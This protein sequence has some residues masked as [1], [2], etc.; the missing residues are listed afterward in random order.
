MPMRKGIVFS[1]DA[2]FALIILSTLLV[3]FFV[4]SE[5]PVLDQKIS[6]LATLGRDYLT[7]KY[8]QGIA[9]DEAGFAQKT[10]L[11]ISEARA[12]DFLERQFV[13]RVT[14]L[15]YP[16]A[17]GCTSFPCILDS[18]SVCLLAQEDLSDALHVAWVATQR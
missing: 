10:G 2:L 1:I 15:Q 8:R 7:L 14:L 17:C 11:S 12:S 3:S 9:I 6:S 5:H 13:A 18:S 16:T 4:F